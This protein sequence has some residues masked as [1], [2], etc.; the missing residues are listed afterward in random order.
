[1]RRPARLLAIVAVAAVAGVAGYL[2]REHSRSDTGGIEIAA[3]AGRELLATSLPDADGN[4]QPL[5]QWRGKVLVLNYWATWCPP[6]MKEIPDF[7]SVSRDFADEPVQFVGISVDRVENV[8]A[9]DER[10]DVPYPLLIAPPQAL[11]A[12]ARLGNTAQALPFTVILDGRGDIAHLKLGVL[13]KSELEGKIRAL[14]ARDIAP[15]SAQ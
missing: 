4:I 7:A 6:C 9:F 3:G 15:N 12:T 11:E 10:M 8:R 1:M 5:D 13:N 2:A 14:L